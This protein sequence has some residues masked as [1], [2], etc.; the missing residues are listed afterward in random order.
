[1]VGAPAAQQEEVSQAGPLP[2]L[3]AGAGLLGLA[4]RRY[5]ALQGPG[6]R[7]QG[8]VSLACSGF[9]STWNCAKRRS[10]SVNIRGVRGSVAETRPE[11]GRA[12]SP[13]VLEQALVGK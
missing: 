7:Q 1:M 13:L 6:S 11:L 4:C 8:A 3:Q 5:S 2:P 9:L 10:H 12:R